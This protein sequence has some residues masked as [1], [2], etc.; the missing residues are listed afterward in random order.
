MEKTVSDARGHSP[1]DLHASRAVWARYYSAAHG[2]HLVPGLPGEKRPHVSAWSFGAISCPQ[3]AFD[4]WQRCPKDNMGVLLGPSRLVSVNIEKMYEAGQAFG[5]VGIDLQ[6]YTLSPSQPMITGHPERVRLMFSCRRRIPLPGRRLRLC[7]PS[8]QPSGEGE[9]IFELRSGRMQDML[10]PSEHP[11]YQLVYFWDNEL[12][13]TGI[14]PL[15]DELLHVWESWES[16]E[17]QM[18]RPWATGQQASLGVGDVRGCEEAPSC[19]E[20]REERGDRTTGPSNRR[21]ELQPVAAHQ[22]IKSAAKVAYLVDDI[23]PV[24]S[25]LLLS[26]DSGIGKT[27]LTLDLAI[28]I[29]QGRPWLHHFPTQQGKV[30]VIDEENAIPLLKERLQKLLRAEDE[31]DDGAT[32]GVHFLPSQ[33]INLGDKVFAEAVERVLAAYQPDLVIVDSLTR[34]HSGSEHDAGAMAHL[35][36]IIKRWTNTYGCCFVLCHPRRPAG[37]REN[38]SGQQ[39]GA[40]VDGHLD[41]RQI[42]GHK[43]VFTV[44]HSKTRYGQPLAPF[45]VEIVDVA[46]QA[47]QVR[48][49][50]EAKSQTEAKL[51]EAQQCI[52][53]LAADRQRHSRHEILRKGTEVGLT[54]HVLD[55]ARKLLIEAGTLDNA[56]E[57]RTAGIILRRRT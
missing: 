33:E 46:A 10:P 31:P 35:F 23:L 44:E 45:A 15:P 56:P 30:L 3:E 14:P 29:D 39:I 57:G 18:L 51:H 11:E 24:G 16:L 25:S 8:A 40:F 13:T 28:A 27:W 20:V 32:L 17:S 19:D 1:P 37:P 9:I 36:R 43:D 41:L 12:W 7:M 34:I 5:E 26:G 2:F 55:M 21:L 49:A 54:Q 48:Y 38:D 47:T 53:N 6:A 42:R 50:G 52:K 4:H 22:L